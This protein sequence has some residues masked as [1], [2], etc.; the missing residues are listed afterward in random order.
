MKPSDL[1]GSGQGREPEDYAQ[2]TACGLF[3]V[4]VA[5]LVVLMLA[6]LKLARCT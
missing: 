2:D 5:A 1:F 6:F 4:I 3:W